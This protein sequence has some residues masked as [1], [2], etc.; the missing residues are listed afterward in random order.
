MDLRALKLYDAD[1]CTSSCVLG[2]SFCSADVVGSIIDHSA[3]LIY[4]VGR[5]LLFLCRTHFGDGSE[6]VRE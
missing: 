2:M 4:G 3:A 6:G 5:I 1:V